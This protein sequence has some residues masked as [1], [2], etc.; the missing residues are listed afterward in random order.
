M[1]EIAIY[2]EGGGETAQQRAELRN[3][4]DGLLAAE[5]Q[6]ARNKRIGWKLVP[7]GSRNETY[8]NFINASKQS[9]STTLC[10]LL[11]DSEEGLPP[12]L[13]PA[14]P[15]T[16][17]E[18][19]NRAAQNAIVRR[20]HLAQRDRWDLKSVPPESIHLM[21]R[22]METWIVADREGMKAV[23][24]S[25]FHDNPL[26]NRLDLEG[27]PKA[28]LNDKLVRATQDTTKGASSAKNNSKIRQASKIL[29]QIRAEE[30]ARRCPRFATFTGWLRDKIDATEKR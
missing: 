6:A 11:V 10:V 19:A 25:H 4:F 22:C 21:V 23:Y 15:A 20:D 17:E 29:E 3:G 27:E 12:E 26:P 18:L 5:K 30:V 9:D 8:K 16:P 7:S 24:G 2:L 14:D 28:S 1:K 13:P